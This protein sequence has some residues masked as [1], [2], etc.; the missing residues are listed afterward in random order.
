MGV[1]KKFEENN[2]SIGI[3][4]TQESLEELLLLSEKIDLSK[5]ET[6]K[7]KKEFLAIRLLLKEIHPNQEI[8]YNKYGAPEIRNGNQ[9]SISHSKNLVAIASSKH[10]VGLDIEQISVK[11]LQLFSKFISKDTCNNLSK[12]KATLIWCCKEAIFK[13]HQKGNVDFKNDI[14]LKPF[15]L[16]NDG[17]ITAIF[18]NKEH[19][20]YYKKVDT[21]FLVYVCT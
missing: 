16:E 1:I 21:H 4:D 17:K 6:K 10:K 18:K 15:I 19:I 3:W 13:W 14:K 5:F 9:I 7:R 2:C 11:P 20:L 12:E 8:L